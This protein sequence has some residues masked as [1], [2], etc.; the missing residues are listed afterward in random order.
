MALDPRFI[1]TN[2]LESYFVDR[3]SGLPL[4]NGQVQFWTDNDRTVP[5]TVYQLTGDP[6]EPGGKD[7]Y[8]YE[9]LPNP[10]TLSATGTIVDDNGN[11]IALYYFPYDGT[12]TTSQGNLELY[13][14]VVLDQY[15]NV[16]FT[17]QAWP[18]L[19]ST[20]NGIEDFYGT[21]IDNQVSNPQF[22]DF[23]GNYSNTLT[24]N[25]SGTST[26]RYLIAPDWYLQLQPGGGGSVTVNRRLITGNQKVT[27][28]PP[29]TLQIIGSV[30]LQ[31]MVLVQVFQ[32]DP[33]VWSAQA[34]GNG[35]YLSAGILL[36]N[37]SAAILSYVP[38]DPL[39]ASTPLL[40]ASNQT[41]FYTY[42]NFTSQL[43][44]SNS[45]QSPVNGN[46][47]LWIQI[48]PSGTTELSSVQLLPL[49]YNAPVVPYLENST[50]RQMD[51]L[52]HYYQPLLS[53]KPISSYLIGWD[54]PVNPAQINGDS[55]AAQTASSFYVWD[56]TIVY[57]SAANLVSFGRSSTF[58][59]LIINAAG[60]GGIALIEYLG[61]TEAIN[62]LS[63][64]S[65]SVNLL[66]YTNATNGL[67]FTINLYY[68]TDSS[69]PMLPNSIVS[70]MNTTTGAITG[71]NGTWIPVTRP[72]AGV[73][74][75]GTL[76]LNTDPAN[77]FINYGFNQFSITNAS[78][79]SSATYFAI[80]VGFGGLVNG[81]SIS[82]KSISL[83]PGNVPTIPAPKSLAET[84]FISRNTNRSRTNSYPCSGECL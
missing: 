33:A 42:Y 32:R 8:D 71:L 58:D 74:A 29:Y 78:S 38:T 1:T 66:A 47:E 60:T 17:R 53:A 70:S 59:G 35:G 7:N 75:T 79:L 13:Y 14:I 84:L 3:N 43:P 30:A 56:Q 50:N 44:P 61:A 45:T 63:N 65:L 2:T 22:V 15:G 55:V 73:N 81:N 68:C 25:F 80:V 6:G 37:N 40:T 83:V 36:A 20:E 18:N 39:A 67:P 34:N 46:A 64:P 24:I 48:S 54:F 72:S 11:N 49:Q 9:A 77:P 5:K 51:H 69:L 31:S 21:G 28:N 19:E 76:S 4:A 16:Q 10:I 52:F 57:Q 27:T 23:Y 41:G 62:I 26:V 12:A 82:I